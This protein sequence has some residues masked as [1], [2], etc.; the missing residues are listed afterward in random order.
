MFLTL[1]WA[2]TFCLNHNLT[3]LPIVATFMVPWHSALLTL[4]YPIDID[5]HHE[6]YAIAQTGNVLW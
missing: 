1:T 4:L 2:S 6:R 5:V 3:I